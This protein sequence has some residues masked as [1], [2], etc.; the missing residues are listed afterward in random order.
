MKGIGK[1]IE[2]FFDRASPI[3]WL[4]LIALLMIIIGSIFYAL[5]I[6]ALAGM[7]I[8]V[9]YILYLL[10]WLKDKVR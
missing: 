6:L 8:V 3:A 4:F 2:R 7:F 10:I 5:Q 1:Y 9:I